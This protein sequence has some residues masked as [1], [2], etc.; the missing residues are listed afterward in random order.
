MGCG[1]EFSSLPLSDDIAETKIIGSSKG[2]KV[3]ITQN[4]ETHTPM[5][6]CLNG[7]A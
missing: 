5:V 2:Y 7:T 4:R 1:A 3:C 6:G